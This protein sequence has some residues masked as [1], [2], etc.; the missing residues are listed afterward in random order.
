MRRIFKAFRYRD[1]RLLWISNLCMPIA[2]W[3]QATTMN[4][5]AYSLTSIGST[6]GEVNA[7]RMIPTLVM[8]PIAGV[9][10]GRFSSIK[11]LAH[12]AA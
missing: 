6:I 2:V 5:V 11:L 1:Y 10:V 7:M 3:I 4:W 12:F 8:S 9:A